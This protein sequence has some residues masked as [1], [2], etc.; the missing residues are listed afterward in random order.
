[1]K[2][3]EL[4][5]NEL[6]D[7]GGVLLLMKHGKLSRDQAQQLAKRLKS[8]EFIVGGKIKPANLRWVED[9]K[10]DTLKFI[11]ADMPGSWRSGTAAMGRGRVIDMLNHYGF[12]VSRFAS[13]AI[14][15]QPER[16]NGP[17]IF[18]WGPGSPEPKKENF[19]KVWGTDESREKLRKAVQK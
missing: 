17:H 12:S 3:C 18:F 14:K 7:F 13:S 9:K 15:R 5:E 2:W 19:E 6:G 11:S 4:L 1:M 10:T 16:N 8:I